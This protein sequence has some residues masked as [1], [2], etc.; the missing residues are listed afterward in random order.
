MIRYRLS[1][2]KDHTHEAWFA[3]SKAFDKLQKSHALTC[4]VCGSVDIRKAIMTPGLAKSGYRS[5]KA[6]VPAAPSV[7]EP[8][9]NHQVNSLALSNEAKAALNAL[10]SIRDKVKENADNVGKNFAE[11][12][13][14]M[15]YG[16]TDARGV[17]GEASPEQTQE[18]AREGI[19]VYPLPILPEDR[20]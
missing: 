14:K 13:R 15:H 9:G 1:C 20:N 3:N 17:W 19:E 18:L 8:A 4:P 12:V 6:S 10:R 16:E 2:E 5:D 7:T 11:E